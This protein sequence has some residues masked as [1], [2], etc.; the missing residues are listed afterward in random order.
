MRMSIQAFVAL[1]LFCVNAFGQAIPQHAEGL[2]EE[3]IEIEMDGGTQ[4]AVLSQQMEATSASKLIVL[5]PGHPSVVR[6]QM[7]HGVMM[8]S[9]MLGNFLIRARRHLASSQTMT[10]L[11]DCH[12]SIGDVCRPEYQASESRYRHVMAAIQA[13]KARHPGIKQVF[14]L[15]TS[16]GSI[17]SGFVAK[18]GQ[19]EFAG[20]IHT[21]TIDPTAPRSYPQLSAL[22]YSDI[23]MPQAFIHHTE[24]PC[25]ITQYGYIR[26]VAEKHN[27]PLV[28]VHGGSDFRGQPCQAF[29][30][31][32]FRG[33]EVPVMKQV[34]KMV[35]ALPWASTDIR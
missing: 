19:Q 22:D 5:L 31:H 20:S 1:L 25:P 29:T 17:S 14:L 8:N 27:I 12:T 11:V 9:P 3:L 15:S 23:R 32:G 21:A 30:Q 4:R 28:S 2:K 18:W 7:G 24:D 34:L 35:N 10:L 6:P 33:K 13:V 26:A 16:L